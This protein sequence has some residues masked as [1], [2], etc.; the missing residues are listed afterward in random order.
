VIPDSREGV[1]APVGD[2]GFVPLVA[3]RLGQSI[4]NGGLVVDDQDTHRR[5]LPSRID[6]FGAMVAAQG[7]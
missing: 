4:G 3:N 6:L 2:D 7:S 5:Y 1:R